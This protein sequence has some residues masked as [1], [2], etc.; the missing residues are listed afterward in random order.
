MLNPFGWARREVA[1]RMSDS[2]I[3]IVDYNQKIN[4]C[5]AIAKAST[6]NRVRAQHYALAEHYMRLFEA[7]DRSA[8]HKRR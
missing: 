4:E 5:V 1:E 2:L 7:E 6:S 3:G 8:D